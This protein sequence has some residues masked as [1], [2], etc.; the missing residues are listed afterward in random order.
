MHLDDGED[1]MSVVSSDVSEETQ[2]MEVLRDAENLWSASFEAMSDAIWILDPEGKVIK[3]NSASM[4]LFGNPGG[5]AIHG[6]FCHELLHGKSSHISDCPYL[7]MKQS[8]K[9]E[10]SVLWEKDRWL[11]VTVVPLIAG[12]GR[13]LGSVHS[14]KDVTERR[15]AEDRVQAL[16]KERLSRETPS[17]I[18]NKVNGTIDLPL[19]QSSHLQAGSVPLAA[20]RRRYPELLVDLK[21]I[22]DNTRVVHALC[23]AAGMTLTGVVKGAAGLPE[24]AKAMA[25]GGCSQLASSRLGQLARLRDHGI[26]LPLMLLRIPG[27]SELGLTIRLADLSLHS[28]TLVLRLA[29]DEADLAGKRHGVVLM[30]DLGDLREGWFDQA[31]LIRAA[32]EVERS[33]P[34]LRLLGVGTNLGCYG[35]I[36]ATADNLGQ[37]VETARYIEDHIGRRLPIVSGGAT[38]SLPLLVKG[39]MPTGITNLRVGEGILTALDLPAYHGTDIPGIESGAFILRLE[40]LEVYE[41]PSYPVGELSVDAFGD[42]PVYKD[43]GTRTRA[44]LGGGKRDFGKHE[45]LVPL[46]P[47]IYPLGSS[48]DHLICDVGDCGRTL[49]PGELIDFKLYYAGMLFS[50]DCP[51][52]RVSYR[53]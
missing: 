6:C 34:G 17:R 38:S 18:K 39:T 50:S 23:K 8:K 32:I 37:L 40:V 11:E 45:A 5:A 46:E 15:L 10:S 48:S 41:K 2:A 7:R 44:I 26:D 21:R 31:A 52:I 43:I 25:K 22:E 3:F 20:D 12:D 24:V 49:K 1:H 51:D 19:L 33:M 35:S 4:A 28:N 30:Q 14:T 36:R 42:T 16:L 29:A 53:A 27:P 47:G 13:L 9:S